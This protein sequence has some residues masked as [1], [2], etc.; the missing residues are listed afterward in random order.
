MATSSP[1][2]R[3]RP[4]KHRAVVTHRV[5]PGRR[6]REWWKRLNIPFQHHRM[7]GPIFCLPIYPC[8]MVMVGLRHQASRGISRVITVVNEFV[9]RIY[10]LAPSIWSTPKGT[11]SAR[12]GAPDADNSA[13]RRRARSAICTQVTAEEDAFSHVR[14]M[15]MSV[16]TMACSKITAMAHR[17]EAPSIMIRTS[18]WTTNVT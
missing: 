11:D 12:W 16:V 9:P 8:I 17:K 18:L 6:T 2:G 4:R 15:R 7:Q 1:A 10:W 5:Q 13:S 3:R 14:P